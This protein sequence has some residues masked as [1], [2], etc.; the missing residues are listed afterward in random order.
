MVDGVMN[1]VEIVHVKML[2]DLRG[3]DS[4]AILD[5]MDYSSIRA[6]G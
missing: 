5:S 6:L 2:Q 1:W 3:L 4:R